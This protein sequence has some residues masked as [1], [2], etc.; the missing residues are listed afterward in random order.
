MSAMTGP[1]MA[2]WWVAGVAVLL[3][4][5]CGGAPQGQSQPTTPTP[6]T[7]Q[8]AAAVASLADCGSYQPTNVSDLEMFVTEGGTCTLSNGGAVTVRRFATQT[9]AASFWQAAG[10]FGLDQSGSVVVGLVAL[11]P[12]R[13]ADVAVIRSAVDQLDERESPPTR[14]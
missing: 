3:L 14:P 11:T 2:R 6:A 1:T 10:E 13:P 9:A 4:A 12:D 8:T 5:G 7:V